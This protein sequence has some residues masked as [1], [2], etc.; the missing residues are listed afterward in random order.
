MHRY[1]PS[2]ATRHPATHRSLPVTRAAAA[3]CFQAEH[4]LGVRTAKAGG[5]ERTSEHKHMPSFHLSV[6]DTK[7]KETKQMGCMWTRACSTSAEAINKPGAFL[8][9]STALKSSSLPGEINICFPVISPSVSTQRE[10]KPK[11][12][13]CSMKTEVNIPQTSQVTCIL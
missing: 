11:H 7:W 12:Q 4:G 13:L 6:D 8:L 3:V 2:W 10:T 9:Y 5:E 1:S